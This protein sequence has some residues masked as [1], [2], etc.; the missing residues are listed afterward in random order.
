MEQTSACIGLDQYGRGG[1]GSW[2]GE[3]VAIVGKG[4]G[5]RHDAICQVPPKS[6]DSG[7]Y[8]S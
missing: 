1:S 2:Q 7:R 8:G 4:I 3:D 6:G 5:A